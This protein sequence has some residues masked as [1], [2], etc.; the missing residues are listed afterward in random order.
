G[1]GSGDPVTYVAVAFLG[2]AGDGVVSRRDGQAAVGRTENQELSHQVASDPAEDSVARND[3]VTDH[4]STARVSQTRP[5]C[6]HALVGRKAALAHGNAE[7]SKAVRTA[8]S[9]SARTG[10]RAKSCCESSRRG[11]IP[12]PGSKS[13]E[14]DKRRCARR[15]SSCAGG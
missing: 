8:A 10:P 2:A 11:R 15:C 14:K 9:A 4:P 7:V 12:K 1:Q 5:R 3:G 6:V 13:R